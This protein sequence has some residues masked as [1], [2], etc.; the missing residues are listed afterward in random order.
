[1][2]IATYNWYKKFKP[3]LSFKHIGGDP[4]SNRSNS[5]NKI[6]QKKLVE[7]LL[8]IIELTSKKAQ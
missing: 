4:R 3:Q 5:I 7:I 8:K 1:M 2:R 6:P